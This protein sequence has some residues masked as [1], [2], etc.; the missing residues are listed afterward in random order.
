MLPAHERDAAGQ[1]PSAKVRKA[2][3]A[4]NSV[5]CYLL[6]TT[7]YLLPTTSPLFAFHFSLFTFNFSLFTFNFS[8]SQVLQASCT[9]AIKKKFP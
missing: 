1:A 4:Q 8:L 2:H 6:P 5:N 7:Y 3:K 9:Q